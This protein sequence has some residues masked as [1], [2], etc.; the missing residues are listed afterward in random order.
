MLMHNISYFFE[1]RFS[2]PVKI[3]EEGRQAKQQVRELEREVV[4]LK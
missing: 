1:K 4:A 2:D 3:I